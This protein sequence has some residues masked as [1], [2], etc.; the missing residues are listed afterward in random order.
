MVSQGAARALCWGKRHGWLCAAAISDG[1]A[2][3]MQQGGCGDAV[4]LLGRGMAYAWLPL[5]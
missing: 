2:A 5:G 4:S 3:A 1:G